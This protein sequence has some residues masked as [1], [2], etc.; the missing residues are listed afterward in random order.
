MDDIY[1]MHPLTTRKTPDNTSNMTLSELIK[2]ELILTKAA[3]SSKDE[4][5]VKL[6]ERIYDTGAEIPISQKDL[7]DVISLRE[8][9]GGTVLPSGLALPH[10]RLANFDG[11]ILTLGV[12]TEPLFNGEFQIHLMTLMISSQSGGLYYLPA[13]AALTKLSR[14]GDF[15][16]RL[17]ETETPESL[18]RIIKERDPELA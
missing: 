5:I 1:W 14:D 17:R 13:V 3:C 11:F 15:L 18:I 10:A 16:S 4:L 8:K 12:P 6:I 9:I 7:L 2:P